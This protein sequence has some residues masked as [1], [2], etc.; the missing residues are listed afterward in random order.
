MK[1]CEIPIHLHYNAQGRIYCMVHN[2]Q[3]LLKFLQGVFEIRKQ[4]KIIQELVQKLGE[5]K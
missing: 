5:N 1:K 3:N 2:W 4:G